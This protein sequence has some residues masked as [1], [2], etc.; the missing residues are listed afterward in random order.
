M[1]Q[2]LPAMPLAQALLIMTGG[3]PLVL[4]SQA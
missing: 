2:I 1:I 4:A 3:L